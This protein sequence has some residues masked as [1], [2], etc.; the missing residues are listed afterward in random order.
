[1]KYICCTSLWNAMIT[2][3]L[4]WTPVSDGDESGPLVVGWWTRWGFLPMHWCPYCD[5]EV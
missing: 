2:R 4:E 5:A 3:A 1:M